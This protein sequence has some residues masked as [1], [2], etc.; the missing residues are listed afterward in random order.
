M[1]STWTWTYKGI[2]QHF[3][4]CLLPNPDFHCNNVL[5]NNFCCLL[6]S[7]QM[8]LAKMCSYLF[9]PGWFLKKWFHFK[10]Y[11]IV[12]TLLTMYTNS[13]LILSSFVLRFLS[14]LITLSRAWEPSN[15]AKNEPKANYE[16]NSINKLI[17][18]YLLVF[19]FLSTYRPLLVLFLVSSFF[20]FSCSSQTF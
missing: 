11:T 4:N 18:L 19:V 16:T 13:V 12:V 17:L 15:Q 20:E 14:M 9:L 1:L 3:H 10:D 7:L 6:N 2:W 8:R 5:K